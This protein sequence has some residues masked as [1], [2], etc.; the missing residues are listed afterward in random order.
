[1]C[2]SKSGTGKTLAFVSLILQYFISLDKLD[3]KTYCVVI[4]PTRELAVQIFQIIKA[5]LDSV[6]M[7]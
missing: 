3:A 7:L 2:Q 4:V 5:L 6:V 1:M